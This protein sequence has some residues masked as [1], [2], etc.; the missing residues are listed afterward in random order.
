MSFRMVASANGV[1]SV[2]TGIFALVAPGVLVSIYQQVASERETALIQML[3]AS[4]VG[5]GLLTWMVRDAVDAGIRRGVAAGS[6]AG[7]AA[8]LAVGFIWLGLATSPASWGNIALQVVFSLAWIYVFMQARQA[9]NVP[10]TAR[11]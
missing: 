2:L 4:Y 11:V 10:G 1:V 8:S 5:F 9:R 7:W 6:A 3:G